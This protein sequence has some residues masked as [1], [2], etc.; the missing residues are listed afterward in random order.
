M[1]DNSDSI[2]RDIFQQRIRKG[3]LGPGSDIFLDEEDKNEEII[4]DFPLQRY[5][6]GVL[7]PEQKLPKSLSKKGDD[8]LNNETDSD[9]TDTQNDDVAENEPDTENYN[10]KNNG[11]SKD[12][13]LKIYQNTFFPSNIGLTFCI[14]STVEELDVEF[15]FG[16]YSQIKKDIKIKV[17]KRDFDEIINHPSFP[18]KE[19]ISYEGGYIIL[20]RKLRG[21][22]KSPRTDEYAKFD[23]FKKSDGFKDSPLPP[24]FHHFEKLLGRTWKRES[25]LIKEKIPVSDVS[26]PTTI[27]EQNLKKET[28][29]C[30][31]ASYTVKTY[32]IPKNRDNT[33]VKIQLANTSDK[34]PSN[35]FSNAKELL[36]Q[37]CIFQAEIKVQTKK[38]KPYKSYIELNPLDKEAEVLNYLYKDKFSY[39]IGHNCSVIWNKEDNNI[40]TTFLPHYDVKDTKNSFSKEDFQDSPDDFNLL[41]KSLDI[42]KLSHFSDNNQTQI[43]EILK[44]FVNLYGNWIDKQKQEASSNKNIENHI[45]EKLDYNLNRLKSNIELLKDDKIF[46]AFQL[47]NTAMLIQIIIS[48]D[49]DF[50]GKEKDLKDLKELNSNV[51]YNSIDFFKDYNFDKLPFNRPKYRPFQLAF[52][53]LNIDSVTDLKSDARNKI[54][55]LI[56]FPT[57]GGKTEAYLSV[58]AFTIIYRRLMNKTGYEGTSVIMRYTL[59]LLTAQQFERASRLI[60]SLEF[61]RRQFEEELKEEPITIGMWVGMSSTPNS[62]EDAKKEVDEINKECNK[63]NGNP[64]SKNAFQISSC[65]WC[66]IKLSQVSQELKV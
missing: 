3:L 61:L 19:I 58:A 37:K 12:D 10:S 42:Y 41:N 65:S 28:S 20:K 32:S 53:L 26:K 13:E 9:E 1:N 40:R 62:L 5:Y 30:F 44:N 52:L 64:E 49:D 16:L 18:F 51:D 54:V 29:D 39:G 17:S 31:R 21:K 46:R 22:S 34:H 66:G 33:Y 59:R 48:N 63:Q 8:E 2:A 55:D 25:I 11:E 47:A 43:I 45:F 27:F 15:N 14:D 56:W 60:V 6:T 24:I 50:S 35:Q 7:F 23:D 38:L 57:G 36:N 4:A